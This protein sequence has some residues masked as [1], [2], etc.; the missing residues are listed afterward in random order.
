MS[1]TLTALFDG[2]ALHPDSAAH[3][4]PN[5]RHAIIIQDVAPAPAKGKA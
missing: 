4:E 2:H 1:K 5:V 3:L